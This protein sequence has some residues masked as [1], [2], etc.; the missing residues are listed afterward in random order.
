MRLRHELKDM[1][2]TRRINT[3]AFRD[4]RVSLTP[5]SGLHINTYTP[6]ICWGKIKLEII[7]KENSDIGYIDA[8]SKFA[9]D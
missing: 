6:I 9:I 2:L 5:Y 1:Q 8:N 4:C 7:L 3:L